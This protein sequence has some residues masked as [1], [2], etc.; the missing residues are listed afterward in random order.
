MVDKQDLRTLFVFGPHGKVEDADRSIAIV[1]KFNPHVYIPEVPVEKFDRREVERNISGYINYA[2]SAT[3]EMKE[4]LLRYIGWANDN[5]LPVKILEDRLT[6]E[7][8]AQILSVAC[9]N[10]PVFSYALG[11][12]ENHSARNNDILSMVKQ[13]GAWLGGFEKVSAQ[14][15]YLREKKI[16]KNILSGKFIEELNNDGTGLMDL[17]EL[18]IALTIGTFHEPMY[19]DFQRASREQSYFGRVTPHRVIF[20]KDQ[21]YAD[22]RLRNLMGIESDTSY[23]WDEEAQ[24]HRTERL[25][26]S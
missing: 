8:K 22:C 3:S 13:V 12:D 6:D 4:C 5:N 18:R 2:N 25:K 21:L 14:M 24:K 23:R 19:R 7:E 11:N 1:E 20:G 15:A 16:I 17:D 26:L 10:Y 9:Q